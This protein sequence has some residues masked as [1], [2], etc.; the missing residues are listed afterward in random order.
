MQKVLAKNRP[1]ITEVGPLLKEWMDNTLSFANA[2]NPP[3]FV[4][5]MRS[6]CSENSCDGNLCAWNGSSCR[7][8]IKKVRP[9][10][11]RSK[12]E[13]RLLSTLVSNEKI[14]DIV[15]QNKASPFFSSI[16]YIELPTELILSDA[17]VSK[18]LR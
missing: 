11:E 10:L 13:K 7:V 5:K 12:L 8:E 4:Q 1:T 14:R 9:S 16:L 3:K 17:D 6:P 2:D 15:W 18:R